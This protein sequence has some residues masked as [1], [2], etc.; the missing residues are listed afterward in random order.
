MRRVYGA[1][2]LGHVQCLVSGD[3]HVL[4]LGTCSVLGRAV[5]A[6]GQE[7]GCKGGLKEGWGRYRPCCLA[8]ESVSVLLL[9]RTTSVLLVSWLQPP[10]SKTVGD[11]YIIH[12]TYGNDFELDVR[13]CKGKKSRIHGSPLVHPRCMLCQCSYVHC[14]SGKT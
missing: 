5:L 12:Y 4:L 13:P 6:N 10:W 1:F 3:K 9:L 2:V 14:V 7:E 8:S 11:A